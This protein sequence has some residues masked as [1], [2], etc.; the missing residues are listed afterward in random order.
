[1]DSPNRFDELLFFIFS[2]IEI[3]LPFPDV[4]QLGFNFWKAGKIAVARCRLAESRLRAS[5]R[6]NTR[7]SN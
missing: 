3:N 6:R 5:P 7:V 4:A 2:F 1:M